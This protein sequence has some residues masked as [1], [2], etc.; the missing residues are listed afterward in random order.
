MDRR[1]FLATTG[2]TV[3]LSAASAQGMKPIERKGPAKLD[4]SLAAYSL[5]GEMKWMKGRKTSGDLLLSDFLDYCHEVG[6]S[7]AELTAYFF[8]SPV[9]TKEIAAL[10]AKAKSL[11]I[12]ISGGA[13]G[14]NFTADPGSEKA[15]AQLQYTR[16]W[17]DHYADLGAPVIRVFGGNPPRGMDESEAVKNIIAN[18]NEALAYAARRKVKLAIENHDFLTRIDRLVA[19]LENFDSPWFGVNFDSGN[20]APTPDPYAD[21]AKLIPYAI[22]VQLKVQIPVN[23]KKEKADLPRI[24]A[25]LQKAKYRGFVVLEYEDDEDPRAAIPAYLKTLRQAMG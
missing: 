7:G 21:L 18:M 20:L 1:H 14:N 9:T 2:S 16:N 25:M 4:L 5:R 12:A 19:L 6:V 13:I 23:G 8:Q 22:N 10:R 15:K 17:I 24:I 11:G 3:A